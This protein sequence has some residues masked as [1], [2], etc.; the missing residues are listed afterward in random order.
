MRTRSD[1][2]SLGLERRLRSLCV[3]LGV[4]V[5]GLFVIASLAEGPDI[6][7]MLFAVGAHA[8]F[9]LVRSIV[10]GRFA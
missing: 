6:G 5:A 10:R 2:Q 7:V 1:L 9:V 3:L 4:Y 8:C